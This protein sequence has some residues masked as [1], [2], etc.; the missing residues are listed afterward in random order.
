MN[1]KLLVIGCSFSKYKEYEKILTW[2]KILSEKINWTI[3]NSSMQGNSLQNQIY[4]L[5]YYLKKYDFDFIIFQ[6]TTAL[7]GSYVIDEKKYVKEMSN[8]R[9]LSENYFT[10]FYIY[11]YR[12]MY[13]FTASPM[14]GKDNREKKFI[15]MHLDNIAYNVNFFYPVFIGLLY[16]IY[17]RLQESKIPYI[18]YCHLPLYASIE[19]QK[20]VVNFPHIDFCLKEKLGEEKF[21]N[22]VVDNG[23]HFNK[24]GNYLLVNE[25]LYP[26]LLSKC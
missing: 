25:Y 18:Y 8:F 15:N 12:Y 16:E 26:L 5:D 2:P 13:N 6:A 22:F 21:N 10:N 14:E 4:Q 17:R 1:K 20:K 23:N 7:R 24:E 11:S 19:S 9:Q 3:Y